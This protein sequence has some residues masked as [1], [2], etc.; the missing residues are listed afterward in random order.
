MESNGYSEYRVAALPIPKDEK[1]FAA[2]KKLI[3]HPAVEY[4]IVDK[5]KLVVVLFE[6]STAGWMG[7]LNELGY[8]VKGGGKAAKRMKMFHRP[9]LANAHYDELNVEFVEDDEYSNEDWECVADHL[10]TDEAKSRLLDGWFVVSDRLIKDAIANLPVYQPDTTDVDEYYYDPAIR[11]KLQNFLASSKVYN[12]RLAGPFGIIKGNMAVSPY[13]PEGVD[14][15]TAHSNVKSEL[16]YKGG[17][18]LL[19]EPQGPKSRVITDDQTI[20]NFP[21]LFPKS[22]MEMWLKEEYDK[23][24]N[25]AINGKLLQNWKSVY[26]RLWKDSDDIEDKEVQARMTYAAYRWV[27]SGMKITDSPWL[28]E[29]LAISHAKPLESKVPI[30]CAVYEQIISESMA[31]M[32]GYDV[33]VET[34]T[35]IR[36][37]ELGVHV[38]NDLDWIEMYLSHG[39]HDGDDFFKLFY[40][41]AVGGPND[42]EKLVIAIRS[43]NGFGE[44]SV[45]RYVEGQ[46]SPTWLK[47]DGT[48][49]KF[50]KISGRGWPMRLSEAVRHNKVT[51]TGLPSDHFPSDAH[52]SE[53]YDQEQVIADLTAAMN[54]GNVGRYVN[55]IMLHSLVFQNHRQE[56]LCSLEA[57]I[58][59]CTQTADPADRAAIDEDAKAIVRQVIE[60]QL[61]VDKA[62]WNSRRFS[63]SLKENE[64]VELYDGPITQLYNM[65][66][67]YFQDYR[68]RVAE[69]AQENARPDDIIH[70]LGSRLYFHAMPYLRR[71]R[72]N[73]YNS[74]TPE[75][76]NNTVS[77]QRQTWDNLYT[78]IV[79]KITSFERIQDQHDFVLALYSVSLKMPTSNGKISDQIVMNR[80]V[81][82]YL[83][84]ALQHYGISK[85][86]NV[87]RQDDGTVKIWQSAPKAWTYTPEGQPSKTFSDVLEYQ[88]FHALHSPVVHTTSKRV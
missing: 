7:N 56:Q 70:T 33:S 12:A 9:T 15:R 3:H 5:T 4:A 6:N 48:E 27:A 30:P 55:A 10:A 52:V 11:S 37:N 8:S 72:M 41:E 51:Y 18:R 79:E 66:A 28:F 85:T 88:K 75:F 24:F 43:P 14:V 61:P 71:F 59:G 57:A 45:F 64:N 83:E 2:A 21:K 76:M 50:P 74:N 69:W 78:N 17:Y 22:D 82:P 46:W 53:V 42:G 44:Y 67:E 84:K 86:L 26:T 38:V 62:F 25:D 49:V 16:V 1:E 36:I 68:R 60:A 13:L 80:I 29:N 77:V 35:I 73:I 63:N 40:R 23:M 20:I 87:A 39:G 32:A 81:L 47:A 65:C 31:R 58:D 54:G 19:A 34:E